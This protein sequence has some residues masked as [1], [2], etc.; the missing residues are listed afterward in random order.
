MF[1]LT[2]APDGAVVGT[3]TS[4]ELRAGSTFAYPQAKGAQVLLITPAS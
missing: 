2:S 1:K 4:A 3:F